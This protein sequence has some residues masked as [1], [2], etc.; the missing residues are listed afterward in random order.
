MTPTRGWPFPLRLLAVAM[1][2]GVAGFG[3]APYG[4]WA[5]TILSLILIVPIFLASE[6]RARAGWIGWVFATGY[7]AH[8]LSWIIEPFQV[9]AERHAWMAPFALLFMAG[10]L[11]L[12]WAVSFWMSRRPGAS[13]FHQSLL[14]IVT[15]SLAELARGYVLTGFPWAGVSQ[16]WIDT[17][18][19]QLL[20]LFGPFGLNALTFAATFPIG[21]AMMHPRPFRGLVQSL[22]FT[23]G[24]A[25]V[26]L[27]YAAIRPTVHDG[28]HVVRVVQPN[29][30]QHQK[31]DPAYAP[32][33]FSRQIEYT[34]A[35][36]EP[37]L[38]VW[39]ETAVPAWL[40]SAQPFLAAIADAAQGTPVVL[41]IQRGDGPRIFNSMIQLD[42]NGQQA[43]LY[44]K[45]HLAPFGEYVPFGDLL[46]RFGI[47]GMAATTGHGFSAGPGPELMD[48][49][50]LGNALPLI[51]YEA[52]FPQD[53]N[54]ASGRAD[55]LLQITNDAWFGTRSGPYQHMVQAR[56]RAI[57]Q[58]LPMIRSANTGISAMIDPLGRVTASLS[59]GEAGYLD[60][61]LPL[62]QQS[63]IY[64]RT[65]DSAVLVILLFLGAII[66]FSA[67]LRENY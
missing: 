1:L 53:V 42:A 19:A 63:T 43:G 28:P 10:G 58:G 5:L 23:A 40:G 12:F 7:F 13:P 38:I 4:Y 48:M 25:V 29:A 3:L 11:A 46:G 49:G 9:D 34:A 6:T 66:L 57:E 50:E 18:V 21:S 14:L 36:P 37:D 31:W 26:A 32:L 54:G 44:D 62:P 27:S 61:V 67:R 8:A 56:M 2:G 45:H 24:L 30:P 51:C 16:V 15:L 60:A 41:G 20:S 55:F 64:S 33:F 22:V 39:P 17:P 35:R 47:H 65:G 59:L 52:V